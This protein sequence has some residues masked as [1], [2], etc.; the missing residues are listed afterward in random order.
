MT[1][2][3][4][5]TESYVKFDGKD[6]REFREWTAATMTVGLKEGWLEILISN[7]TLDRAS[8]KAE[9]MA[10]V[11]KNDLAYE[12]MAKTCT[13]DALEY[14]RV[15]AT[16]DSNGDMRKA[17]KGL[18]K[19]YQSIVDDLI[20]L[21]EEYDNCKMKKASDDPCKWY[22][23]LEYLQLWMEHAGMQKKTKAEMVA[24]IMN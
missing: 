13:D 9:D 5:K 17:W 20:A 4:N 10:T 3:N 14:V 11:L 8:E 15:A 16:A 1:S 24:F 19:R 12:F 6:E 22:M 21:S 7:V 2:E 18:C 23:E